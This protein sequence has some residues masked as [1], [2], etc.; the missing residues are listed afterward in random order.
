MSHEVRQD[1][2]G[3]HWSVHN[4]TINFAE[5]V[6]PAAVAR[7]YEEWTSIV[8]EHLAIE[9]L[10]NASVAEDDEVAVLEVEVADGGAVLELETL[11][12]VNMS[13]IDFGI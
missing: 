11:C 7:N 3:G 8:R 2:K 5:T 13:V 4:C 1:S 9:G 12:S 10:L 6:G